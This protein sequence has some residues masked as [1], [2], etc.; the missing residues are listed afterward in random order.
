MP[1]GLAYLAR[2]SVLPTGP[3]WPLPTPSSAAVLFRDS[4]DLG[5]EVVSLIHEMPVVIRSMRQE[6]NAAAIADRADRVVF[7]A[8]LVR[9]WRKLFGYR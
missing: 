7:A 5:F 6:E 1:P 4:S 3:A 8:G 2:Y 9:A